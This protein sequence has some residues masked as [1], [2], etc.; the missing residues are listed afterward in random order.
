MKLNDLDVLFNNIDQ[1]F[2]FIN[3]IICYNVEY[4]FIIHNVFAVLN[5][6]VLLLNH[7]L[8]TS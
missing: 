8:K 1:A 2:H 6:V 5:V 3:G 4:I 7:I